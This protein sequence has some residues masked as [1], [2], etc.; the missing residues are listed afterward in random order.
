MNI[1][2]KQVAGI[3]RG[4]FFWLDKDYHLYRNNRHRS[5]NVKYVY[6]YFDRP[7]GRGSEQGCY[8]IDTFLSQNLSQVMFE[9]LRNALNL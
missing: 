7:I 3:Q 8:S 2:A 6:C 5:E 1:P 9:V 4:S